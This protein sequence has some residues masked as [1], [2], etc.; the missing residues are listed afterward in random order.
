M[1]MAHQLFHDAMADVEEVRQTGDPQRLS[2]YAERQSARQENV[3]SHIHDWVERESAIFMKFKAAMGTYPDA[4]TF[5]LNAAE[6]R[7]EAVD[8]LLGAMIRLMDSI[9]HAWTA[10]SEV[11]NGA[12]SKEDWER[13]TSVNVLTSAMEWRD[14]AERSRAKAE[15]WL[16]F[17]LK[18]ELFV[19]V[20]PSDEYVSPDGRCGISQPAAS[21]VSSIFRTLLKP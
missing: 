16:A 19:D 4:Q 10:L 1:E 5:L 3:G 15:G 18:K 6:K 9:C 7:L 12:P 17:L 21:S 8:Y 20:P 11:T 13:K 2:G 14:L